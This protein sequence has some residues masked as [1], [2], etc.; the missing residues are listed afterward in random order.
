MS[1]KPF[2]LNVEKILENWEIYHAVREIIANAIDEELLTNT[3]KI[4]IIKDKSAC[5]H[6]RDYGRG[7]NYQHLT[8]KENDEKL[9]NPHVIGKFGIGLKDALATFNRKGVEVSIKSG[10]GDITLGQTEKHGFEDVVTLHAYLSPPSDS[11]FQGTEF[12]LK[13]CP[14]KDIA[15]AKDLFL[16]FSGEKLLET[17]QYGQVL[18]K[19][20]KAARIYV[21]GVQVAEEENFLFSYNITALNK[22]IQ[23]ALNRERTNVGRTAYAG[24]I[25]N[26]LTTCQNEEVARELVKDL[27]DYDDGEHHDELNWSEVS[28]H[29]CKLLNDR[30]RVVF[31][32]SGE[33]MSAPNL[34]D[35]ARDDNYDVVIIPQKIREKLRGMEDISGNPIRDMEQFKSDWNNSFKFSFVTEKQLNA[36]EKRIFEQTERILSFVVG[37]PGIVKEV[38]ISTTMRLDPHSY[39]EAVGLWDASERRII[40]KRDQLKTLQNYAGILLHEVAHATSGATDITDGFEGELTRYLGMVVEKA[41]RSG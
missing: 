13:G 20:S 31:F 41:I 19:K 33:A 6:I 17:T 38:L 12:I 28:T 26:I 9:N 2:D 3:K 24:R 37:R 27:A 1:V 18:K 14:D 35:K 4:E 40:V 30:S 29:A 25:Q 8:Q 7:L 22:A 32:T 21:N 15:K 39:H 23:K 36:N 5:W 11:K 10:H 34:V 16:R